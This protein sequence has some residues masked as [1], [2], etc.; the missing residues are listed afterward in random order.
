MPQRSY[1]AWRSVWQERIEQFRNRRRDLR[2][3]SRMLHRLGA[4]FAGL[5]RRLEEIKFRSPLL[6]R[7][8]TLPSQASGSFRSA[9]SRLEQHDADAQVRGQGV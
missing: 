2:G 8:T 6:P 9:S 3:L 4:F 7:T 5:P 1:A